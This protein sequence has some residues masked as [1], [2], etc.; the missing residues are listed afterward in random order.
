MLESVPQALLHFR[1]LPTFR[2]SLKPR[3]GI[4]CNPLFRAS[5]PDTRLGS[6]STALLVADNEGKIVGEPTA[7]DV[8]NPDVSIA[9]LETTTLPI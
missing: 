7:R 6:H 8:V 1:K 5:A 4:D 9:P 2:G 3:P